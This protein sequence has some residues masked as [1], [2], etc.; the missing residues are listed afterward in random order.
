MT[1]LR[2]L[3]L[4]STLPIALACYAFL[5][6]TWLY[7]EYSE[8]GALLYAGGRAGYLLLTLRPLRG[9]RKYAWAL[10]IAGLVGLV[11]QVV[12]GAAALLGFS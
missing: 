3:L 5:F 8:A 2:A 10:S 6:L 7:G 1:T 12:V 4:G 11:S 9:V